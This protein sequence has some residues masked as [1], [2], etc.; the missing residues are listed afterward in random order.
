MSIL[1]SFLPVLTILLALEQAVNSILDGCPIQL[2]GS[3]GD[4]NTTIE[5]VAEIN[6]ELYPQLKE[7]LCK[8]YFRFVAANLYNKCE[9]WP[10]DG[11]CVLRACQIE[12]C[13][14]SSV[15]P[16]LR[17]P[18]KDSKEPTSFRV[19]GVDR[20]DADCK[21][22]EESLTLGQLDPTLSSERKDAIDTWAD[23]DRTDDAPFCE[24]LGKLV[25]PFLPTLIHLFLFYYSL[26]ICA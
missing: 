8:D 15:P 7:L 25:S 6:K 2:E 16:G 11:Q 13:S 17:I 1:S 10:E 22:E 20:A 21:D 9:F 24:P 3:I 4:A 26:E 19:M 18:S 14:A 23:F 12:D 5:R